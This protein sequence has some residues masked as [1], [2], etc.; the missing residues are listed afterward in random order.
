[1]KAFKHAVMLTPRFTFEVIYFLWFAKLKH[2]WN[3]VFHRRHCIYPNSGLKPSVTQELK[4]A[5]INNVEWSLKC[6]EILRNSIEKS[7]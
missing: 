3:W 6:M 5:I 2:I 1:M 7:Y 4:A